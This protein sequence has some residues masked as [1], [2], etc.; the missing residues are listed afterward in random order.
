[1]SLYAIGDLQGCL[2]SLENLLK[3][4]NFKQSDQLI[5][6]GDLVNR[7]RYSLESLRFIKKI[8]ADVVLG[9]HDLHTIGVYYGIRKAT[10]SDTIQNVIQSPD[11]D[12][13]INWLKSKPLFLKKYDHIFVHAGINP[14]WSINQCMNYNEKVSIALIK[15]PE[16]TLKRIFNKNVKNNKIPFE[17]LVVNFF[18]RVRYL[19]ENCELFFKYTNYPN[20]SSYEIYPWYKLVKKN[21]LYP[22]IFGHWSQLG[23]N[24]FNNFICLDSGCVWGGKLTALRIDDYKIFQV[25]K[26]SKD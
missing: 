18:T 26:S 15:S 21:L 17:Q 24:F 25:K 12:S 5:F 13:L 8:N 7:G 20:C 9:N 3:L 19:N 16:T 1:M 14:L 6:L 11:S 22:L 10:L 2:T 4:I 23:L